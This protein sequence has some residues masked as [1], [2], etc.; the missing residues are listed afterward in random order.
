MTGRAVSR[1]DLKEIV[2]DLLARTPRAGRS[3]LVA[4]DGPSGAGKT[5]LAEAF[6]EAVRAR[7]ATVEVVHTD[8]LLDGWDDQ[9]TFWERLHEQVLEPLRAGRAGRYQRYD[10]LAGRFVDEPTEVEPADVVI[11]EGVSTAR[12]AMRAVADL[13]VFLGVPDELAWERLTARD[14]VDALPFLRI[15]KARE[16]GHFVADRTAQEAD[17]HLDGG[18]RR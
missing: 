18:F 1:A 15:W 4:I 10:W 14:P 11:I 5:T 2:A 16:I 17:L 9:F 13:T 12:R 3:R 8:D 6:A 7:G